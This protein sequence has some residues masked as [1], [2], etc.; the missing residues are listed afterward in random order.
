[1]QCQSPCGRHGS[2]QEG[3]GRPD[4]RF[5]LR[6][7]SSHRLHISLAAAQVLINSSVSALDRRGSSTMGSTPA[8]RCFTALAS[9]GDVAAAAARDGADQHSPRQQP[10]PA[11]TY[12]GWLD[13]PLTASAD[14]LAHGRHGINV[15]SRIKQTG[16]G[17]VRVGQH[18]ASSEPQGGGQAYWS[19]PGR[20]V[21]VPGSYLNPHAS[22]ACRQL[23]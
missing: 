10:I 7:S 21:P 12:F 14:Q 9:P 20:Q 16:S 13:H 6:R 8:H 15:S 2:P 22:G 3:L 19:P 17:A 18:R 11:W 4:Q 23:G 5:R 1:M